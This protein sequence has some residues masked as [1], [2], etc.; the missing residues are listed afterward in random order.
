VAAVTLDDDR[1]SRL[2]SGHNGLGLQRASPHQF[3]RLHRKT[4]QASLFVLEPHRPSLGRDVQ[5]GPQ[6]STAPSVDDVDWRETFPS[7]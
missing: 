2:R 4:E 1:A 5:R 6:T 3:T 7:E